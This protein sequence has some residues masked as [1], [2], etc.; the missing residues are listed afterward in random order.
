MT[1]GD[2]LFILLQSIAPK[3]EYK[4]GRTMA[5]VTRASESRFGWWSTQRVLQTLLAVIGGYIL[6]D[7]IVV[8][9]SL[10]IAFATGL[11]KGEAATLGMLLGFLIYTAIIVW[12]FTEMRVL[13]LATIMAAG[14]LGSYLLSEF[15]VTMVP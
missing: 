3:R 6:S 13:R 2:I 12:A 4:P 1:G 5:V 10:L 11:P 7:W 9:L 8:W 15:L 14:I